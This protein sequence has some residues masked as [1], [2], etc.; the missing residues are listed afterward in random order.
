M[1]QFSADSSATKG[2]SPGSLVFIGEQ[3]MDRPRFEL[4]KYNSDSYH[5]VSSE[6]FDEIQKEITDSSFYWLNV[7][8][9]HDVEL[10][11]QIGIA[12]NIHPLVLEDIL[13]TDQRPKTEDYGDYFFVTV[14][15]LWREKG[16]D[17]IVEEQFSMCVFD[18]FVISFQEQTGDVFDP[19]RKRF[20][21]SRS[22]LRTEGTDYLAY[23]LFDTIID[24]YIFLSE[25]VGADIELLEEQLFESKGGAR[26]KLLIKR[27]S[28]Y[29]TRINFMRKVIRPATD[30]VIKLIKN[31]SGQISDTNLPYYKDLLS[32]CQHAIET[33]DVYREV[34]HDQL[35]VYQ[36]NVA[37]RLN[38]IMKV[39]TVFS[40][41]F[42]PLTFLTGVYGTN[43]EHI[44]ETK[45]RYGFYVFLVF[46]LITGLATWIYF[47]R[48][49]WL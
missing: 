16:A 19:I 1:I 9:L 46:L 40:A 43:F 39:L 7:E 44:P 10:I 32:L 35:T 4:I 30:V 13:N 29:K 37:N 11:K 14:Q 33:V 8:G 36:T 34:L 20:G 22:R 24:N 12:Y 28:S 15:M 17:D 49:K 38:E 6:S 48:K 47:K 21:N 45:Q 42:I 18:D 5:G 27:I 3:K 23:A 31:T 25:M 41:V 26:E 2:L